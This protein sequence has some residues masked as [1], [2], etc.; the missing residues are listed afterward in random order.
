MRNGWR[1]EP[2]PL[3]K[4]EYLKQF[5]GDISLDPPGPSREIVERKK[6]KPVCLNFK[7][8]NTSR[9]FEGIFPKKGAKTG[10]SLGTMDRR[11]DENERKKKTRG[12]ERWK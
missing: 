9:A 10:Y 12:G 5:Y 4:F 1:N 7:K 11:G 2:D 6:K 3:K 8:R